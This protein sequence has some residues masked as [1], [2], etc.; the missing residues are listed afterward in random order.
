VERLAVAW[1]KDVSA[2]AL[3]PARAEERSYE[4]DW[5]D[6]LQETR[7]RAEDLGSPD[8]IDY[9]DDI[10]RAVGQ[11]LITAGF[12]AR[13]SQYKRVELQVRTPAIDEQGR[14]P[15]GGVARRE[16][17]RPPARPS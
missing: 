16:R 13:P 5:S 1:F 15:A 2:Q 4:V 12:P 14:V 17:E 8:P 7:T 6:I 3:K 9:S 10:K 11:L